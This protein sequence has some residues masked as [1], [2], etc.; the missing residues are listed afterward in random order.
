MYHDCYL[1]CTGI[2]RSECLPGGDGAEITV[3]PLLVTDARLCV[4]VRAGEGVL[5]RRPVRTVNCRSRW[6]RGVSGQVVTV[7]PGW[8][9]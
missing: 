1:M 6:N 8:M 9:R 3:T 5:R 4:C 7:I 2:S